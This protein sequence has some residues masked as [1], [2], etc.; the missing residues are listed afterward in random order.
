V[1]HAGRPRGL[2]PQC[3]LNIQGNSEHQFSGLHSDPRRWNRGQ[4]ERNQGWTARTREHGKC[5]DVGHWQ[6]RGRKWCVRHTYLSGCHWLLVLPAEQFDRLW[7]VS[8]IFFTS[9]KDYWYPTAKVIDFTDPLRNGSH[10][11]T[12][13]PG[14]ITLRT[15]SVTFS[16]ESGRSMA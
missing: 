13:D 6:R 2:L 14:N 4:Y 8:K 15:F 10:I 12:V 1:S 16:R 11:N 7:V 9:Y 3:V 5:R